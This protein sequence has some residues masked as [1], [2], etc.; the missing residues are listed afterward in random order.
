MFIDLVSELGIDLSLFLCWPGR[1]AALSVICKLPNIQFTEISF[2]F[3]PQP[4][5]CQPRN[6]DFN[7]QTKTYLNKITTQSVTIQSVYADFNN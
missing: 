2:L 7:Q 1:R 5:A 4:A 3:Q 6:I